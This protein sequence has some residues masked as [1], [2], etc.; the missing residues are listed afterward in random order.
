MAGDGAGEVGPHFAEGGPQGWAQLRE[1][2]RVLAGVRAGEEGL[3]GVGGVEVLLR[4]VK[5]YFIFD[6]PHSGYNVLEF[7]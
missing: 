7:E 4:E 3:P 2:V 5:C 1:E 6:T